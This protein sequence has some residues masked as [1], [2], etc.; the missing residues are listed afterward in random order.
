[1]DS[2]I[3]QEEINEAIY[4]L[5]ETATGPDTIHNKMLKMMT[6]DNRT[7]LQTLF[8]CRIGCGTVPE[9]WKEA[10]V[11][12][13]PKPG[14]EPARADA[15][16]A[17]SL[18]S[19]LGKLMEKVIGKRLTWFL[20]KHEKLLPSQ[21]GFRIHR[22]TTDSLLRLD[23]FIKDAW[24]NGKKV[25][26]IMLNISKAFDSATPEGVLYILAKMGIHGKTLHWLKSF[27]QDRKYTVK[28]S[29][30]TSSKIV[31]RRGVPQGSVLSPILFNCLMADLPEPPEQLEA[32]IYADD[33]TI[34]IKAKDS[35]NA[36]KLAQPYLDELGEWGKKRGLDFSAEKTT[37]TEFA[38][39]QPSTKP[40][41]F[42]QGRRTPFVKEACILGLRVDSQLS[43][44]QYIGK[45]KE[46]VKN[47]K[48]Q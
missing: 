42:I 1:M 38:L 10:T 47:Q 24:R 13:L 12:P 36:E 7:H 40:L 19:T 20:E 35:R 41:F 2:W 14:K 46:D 21:D 28:T 44:K 11:I 25:Y 37:A 48:P 6:P 39:R 3:T 17:I 33:V 18:T 22:G 30:I 29:G 16:R 34:M 43:W 9:A 15:F 26:G 31:T 8:N 32:I 5:R 45:L 23:F 27:L 4:G